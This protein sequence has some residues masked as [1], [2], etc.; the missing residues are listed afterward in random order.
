MFYFP[1]YYFFIYRVPELP[2]H[3]ELQIKPI[4][5]GQLM[6]G[7][8]PKCTQFSTQNGSHFLGKKKAM[9]LRIQS[10]VQQFRKMEKILP[11]LTLENSKRAFCS[12]SKDEINQKSEAGEGVMWTIL[13]SISQGCWSVSMRAG[14]AQSLLSLSI[15][16]CLT[17]SLYRFLTQ[18][19]I[20]LRKGPLNLPPST[21]IVGW[22]ECCNL[23]GC[24]Q[25]PWGSLQLHP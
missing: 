5:Q 1:R 13:T 12:R 23:I 8:L 4:F 6:Y 24:N 21:E 3:L 17:H 20:S 18:W 10:F 22:Q 11:V 7:L 2:V 14:P 19:D 15:P 25:K 16:F 9:A